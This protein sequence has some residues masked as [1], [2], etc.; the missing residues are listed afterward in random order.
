MDSKRKTELYDDLGKDDLDMTVESNYKKFQEKVDL[1]SFIDYYAT[2]IYINNN[3][4]WSGCGS[5]YFNNIMM[6]RVKNPGGESASNPYGD[7]FACKRIA[8]ILEK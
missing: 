8:D 1:D 4:W 3:D 2:E 7:G 5:T 6:W